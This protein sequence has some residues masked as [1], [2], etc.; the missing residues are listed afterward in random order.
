MHTF[1]GWLQDHGAN[2]DLGEAARGFDAPEQWWHGCPHAAELL[3]VAARVGIARKT[4]VRVVC[5][6]LELSEPQ[7]VPEKVLLSWRRVI[8]AA[9]AWLRGVV[10]TRS[11]MEASLA[12]DMEVEK[13]LP[14]QDIDLILSEDEQD[15][16]L[17]ARAASH[18]GHI[19]DAR[20]E[21]HAAGEALDALSSCDPIRE[22]SWVVNVRARIPWTEISQMLEQQAP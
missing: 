20:H 17:D 2:G 6:C 15:A 4:L 1:L 12:L 3:W 18:L 19:A 5:D 7:P 11:L 14:D 16:L 22:A 21:L 9:E 10:E 8:A 13:A